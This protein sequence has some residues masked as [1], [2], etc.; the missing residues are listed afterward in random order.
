[1]KVVPVPEKWHPS[2][3]SVAMN[4]SP[5]SQRDYSGLSRGRCSR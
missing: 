1:M 3:M 4:S 2:Q 5:L